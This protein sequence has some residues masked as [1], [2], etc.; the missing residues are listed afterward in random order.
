MAI[1]V[2]ASRLRG[3]SA[4]MTLLAATVCLLVAPWSWQ[5][6]AQSIALPL[7]AAT[8]A[9]LSTDRSLRYR[10]TLAVFPVLVLWANVHGSVTLGAALV[11]LAGLFAVVR[12]AHGQGGSAG[13]DL[14]Y[15]FVPWLC[16]LVSPYGTGLIGYYKLLFVDSP[17]SKYIT[18]WQAPPF[19]GYF[20]AF[21]A[22]GA[23]TVVIAVWQ[24][25]R[26]ALYDL[27]V[28]SLTL[29]GACRSV[30]AVVWF[31]LAMAILLPVALDGVVPP[32]SRAPIHRRLG[33][34]L[35]G[36]LAMLVAAVG[37]F[38]VT[39]SDG[40]F[41]RDW[42]SAPARAAVLAATG[43]DGHTFVWSGGTL[44]DYLLWKDER[45]RGRIAWDVRFELLTGAELRGIVRF[46]AGKAG[47]RATLQGY[48][49][50]VLDRRESK[51]QIRALLG[52]PGTEVLFADAETV[53]LRR[54]AGRRR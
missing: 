26:L 9:L 14:L 50:V 54:P 27:I 6:R 22:V 40:W 11:S 3:A 30:R 34:V 48:P 53:V 42:P 15:L 32:G 19:H 31:A 35:T 29:A 10:R 41:E 7:F 20:L 33:V 8:L 45:L 46:N 12:R 5:L 16:V 2:T 52:E 49:V 17:V 28:L 38:T 36:T 21:Y 47:W 13:R 4:R 23:A 25:R 44:S 18:E 1:V 51:A 24:R 43:T 39:R 37:V